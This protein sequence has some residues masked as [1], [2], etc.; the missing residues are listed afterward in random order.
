MHD[1]SLIADALPASFAKLLYCGGEIFRVAKAVLLTVL[2]SY[3]WT[4]VTQVVLD[5]F[6]GISGI[7]LDAQ[8]AAEVRTDQLAG[9]R[10]AEDQ[11]AQ[12][13]VDT[14]I[15]FRRSFDFGSV[16]EDFG[17]GG[18]HH[19]PGQAALAGLGSA[20]DGDRGCRRRI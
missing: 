13:P 1:S 2:A 9:E 5:D 4:H 17:A 16:D 20:A 10:V 19:P 15:A 12:R 3:G 6:C 11:Q 18:P 7:V 14:N 8:R